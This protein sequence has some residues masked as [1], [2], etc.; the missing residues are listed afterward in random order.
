MVVVT[1]Q[2]M[3]ERKGVEVIRLGG[4]DRTGDGEEEGGG[5]RGLVMEIGRGWWR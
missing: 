4:G 5:D 1:G 2:V 3:G